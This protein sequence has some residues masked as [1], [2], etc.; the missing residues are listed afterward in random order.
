MRRYCRHRQ[1][2]VVPEEPYAMPPEEWERLLELET[3]DNESCDFE[4]EEP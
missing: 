4:E 2:P 3:Y 1:P